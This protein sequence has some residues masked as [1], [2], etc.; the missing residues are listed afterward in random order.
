MLL[1]PV[2][3]YIDY[4]TCLID[5]IVEEVVVLTVITFIKILIYPRYWYHTA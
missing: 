3:H 2:A 1:V 5:V 4:I